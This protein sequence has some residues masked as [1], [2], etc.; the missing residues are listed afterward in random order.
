MLYQLLIPLS[1]L[2]H[3]LAAP[4]SVALSAFQPPLVVAEITSGWQTHV[5]Q[6]GETLSA[7]AQLYNL[8]VGYLVATN[9]ILDP[10]LIYVGQLLWLPANLHSSRCEVYH[11][12]SVGETVSGIAWQYNVSLDAILLRNN[13][14]QPDLVYAGTILIIPM[15]SP[16]HSQ[17]TINPPGV[18]APKQ[19]VVDLSEQRAY[20]YQGEQLAYLFVVSTGMP[21]RETAA[22]TYYVENK[23]PMANAYTW[24][25]Q[26]PMWVGWN[27]WVGSLETGYLQN[28][29]HA[30]PILADGTQLW[31]GFLGTPVSY[32]C[33]VLSLSDAKTLYN[34]VDIGTPVVVQP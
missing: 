9:H 22:G 34:W 8:E 1:T 15:P 32:G 24:S 31:S 12:V 29:F 2:V 14:W 18:V 5:V 6:P 23:L 3:S 11:Q 16:C 7:I 28:G 13:L 4:T 26:L 27:Y 10:D 30:L 33:V 25:L 19:I 17:D 21:G 20:L